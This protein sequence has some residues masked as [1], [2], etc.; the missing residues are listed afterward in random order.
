MAW[1]KGRK[2]RSLLYLAVAGVALGGTVRPVAAARPLGDTRVFTR[3]PAPGQPEGLAVRGNVVYVGTHTSA[4]GNAGGEPSRLFRYNQA[5]GRLIDAVTVQ[6]QNVEAV[7]G[8]VGMSFGPDG[9]LYVLDRDPPRLLAFDVAV[10][11]PAQSTFATFPALPRCS[12]APSPCAPT[13]NP[14]GAFPDALVFDA[15]G[16]A[17]VTDVQQAT[18]FYVPPGGGAAS[19][20]FQDRRLD[21]PFGANGID[22]DPTGTRV[23]FAVTISNQPDTPNQGSVYSLPVGGPPAPADLTLIHRYPEPFAAPDGIIYGRT[24]RLYVALAGANQISVLDGSREVARFPTAAANAR[25]E[26]P[27]DSPASPVFDGAGGLLV[28][29]QSYVNGNPRSWAVLDAWVD[30]TAR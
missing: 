14:G 19:V 17:Y 18:I 16:G 1:G 27:Y 12:A 9:R 7:H 28:T 24:G 15:A 25:Q 4:V 8:L 6:G 11:P 23:V 21:G 22:L 5:T 30:D 26:V 2:A 13:S 3:V 29:N 20:W 10:S